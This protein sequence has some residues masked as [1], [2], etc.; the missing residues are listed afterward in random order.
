MK[1]VCL[2]CSAVEGLAPSYRE[3]A[4]A[5]GTAVAERGWR[6]V[7]GGSRRGLMGEAARAAM[8]AGGTVVGVI[9]TVLVAPEVAN[10]D[11]TEL[12]IVETLAQR[13]EMMAELSD[14]FVCLPGGIGT[15]DELLEMITTFDLG[16]HTKPTILTSIGGFWEPFEALLKAFDAHGVLRARMHRSYQVVPDLPATLAA[17]ERHFAR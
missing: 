4:Q 8:A 11:I 13:K 2:F 3:T 17:L 1:S 10:R 7:Y 15:L 5:F 14:A 9:P 12:R 16:L 6:L